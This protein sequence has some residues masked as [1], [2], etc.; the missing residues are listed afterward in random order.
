MRKDRECIERQDKRYFE[1]KRNRQRKRTKGGKEIKER[2]IKERERER[3]RE[4][5]KERERERERKPKPIRNAE[6]FF[7]AVREREKSQSKTFFVV[8]IFEE[9]F[10]LTSKT[11]FRQTL[12]FFLSNRSA[13]KEDTQTWWTQKLG[14]ASEA[15]P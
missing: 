8:A 2:E 5:E 4:R 10:S 15:N 14:V 6:E 13:R 1:R 9:I 3:E 7:F 12:F 11:G